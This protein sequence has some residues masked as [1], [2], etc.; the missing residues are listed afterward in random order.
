MNIEIHRVDDRAFLRIGKLSVEVKEYQ[1][2]SSMRGGTE[3]DVKIELEPDF[4][5]FLTKANSK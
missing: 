3:L 4:I 1:I 5:E 2:S